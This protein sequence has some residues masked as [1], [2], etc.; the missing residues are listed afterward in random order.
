MLSS[1]EYSVEVEVEISDECTVCKVI[2]IVGK[3]LALLSYMPMLKKTGE[4]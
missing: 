1:E 3:L 4:Q 2:F